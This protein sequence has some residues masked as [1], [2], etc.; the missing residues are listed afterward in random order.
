MEQVFHPPIRF[1]W[2]YVIYI[3]PH[4]GE[5]VVGRWHGGGS[6]KAS[7]NAQCYKDLF[8]YERI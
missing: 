7:L 1:M 6:F 8:D 3:E 2:R 5:G 4:K